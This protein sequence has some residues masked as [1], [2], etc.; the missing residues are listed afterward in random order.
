MSTGSIGCKSANLS[1]SSVLFLLSFS[2]F[3]SSDNCKSTRSLQYRPVWTCIGRW[4]V[5]QEQFGRNANCSA[6]AYK[7][8]LCHIFQHCIKKLNIVTQR[9]LPGNYK[10]IV[11]TLTELSPFDEF[12]MAEAADDKYINLSS[13]QQEYHW[14]FQYVSVFMRNELADIAGVY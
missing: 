2:Q 14:K 6:C 4:Q 10:H 12:K 8:S 13:N 11:L 1:T 3:T 7:Y 9:R 5:A